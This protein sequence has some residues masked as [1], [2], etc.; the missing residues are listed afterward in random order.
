MGAAFAADRT[1]PFHR[2]TPVAIAARPLHSTARSIARSH[3]YPLSVASGLAITARRPSPDYTPDATPSSIP[4]HA[5]FA[6]SFPLTTITHN[7]IQLYK[8][9]VSLLVA[10]QGLARVVAC[11]GPESQVCAVTP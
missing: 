9:T 6:W 2:L 4:P 7:T 1:R 3:A 8:S 5:L 11:L 10:G